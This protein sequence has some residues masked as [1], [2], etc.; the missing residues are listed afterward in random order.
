MGDPIGTRQRLLLDRVGEDPSTRLAMGLLTVARQIDRLNGELFARYH[1][2]DGRFVA[3]LA[4]SAQPGMSSAALADRIGVTRATVTGLV[5]GLVAAGLMERV[6]HD[7]DRRSRGLTVTPAGE[8]ALEQAVPQINDLLR[9]LVSGIDPSDRGATW[10]AFTTIQD[11]LD[12]RHSPEAH[13][14]PDAGSTPA[15]ERTPAHRTRDGVRESK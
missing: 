7:T 3:L 12:T 14:A 9:S 4:V 5:D 10:R 15:S 11:H 8:Q 6:T 2:S 13:P 1:L